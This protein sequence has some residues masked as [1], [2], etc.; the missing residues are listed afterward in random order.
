MARTVEASHER[1]GGRTVGPPGLVQRYYA[2][3]VMVLLHH[4]D[5]GL[6]FFGLLL[7]LAEE[8]HGDV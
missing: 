5:L 8:P 7:V 6:A 4:L 2:V 3:V 1:G